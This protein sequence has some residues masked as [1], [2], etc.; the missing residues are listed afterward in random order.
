MQEFMII[1]SMIGFGAILM[2][3]IAGGWY[4]TVRYLRRD[5]EEEE[6]YEVVYI[7]EE[8]LNVLTEE[9]MLELIIHERKVI[10]KIH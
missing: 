2:V 9:A 10:I 6:S 3:L 7:T 4:F 5:N 1:L 8:Q